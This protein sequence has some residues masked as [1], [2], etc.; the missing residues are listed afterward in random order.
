MEKAWSCQIIFHLNQNEV[1]TLENEIAE[2]DHHILIASACTQCLYLYLLKI[3]W[4]CL[5]LVQ[6]YMSKNNEIINKKMFYLARNT[7]SNID[8][9]GLIL[10]CIEITI[11][12]CIMYEFHV[13]SIQFNML[14]QEEKI[15]F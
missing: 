2:N 8:N 14:S 9:F 1:D 15:N 11:Y 4:Q 10:Q 6:K 13:Q 7:V 3:N 12:S 5:A